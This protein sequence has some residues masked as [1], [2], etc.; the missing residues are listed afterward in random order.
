MVVCALPIDL[1]TVPRL[2]NVDPV[3]SP[4][5]MDWS[6]QISK[7]APGRLFQTAP[8]DVTIL[9]PVQ[10]TAPALSTV[11]PS[12]ALVAGP[13]MTKVPLTLVWPIPLIAPLSQVSGP[14]TV[15]SP[16]P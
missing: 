9:P 2:L 11:R 13:L 14:D 1:R 4:A 10:V 8:L 7:M 6:L 15:T 12:S 3:P 16:E 5:V